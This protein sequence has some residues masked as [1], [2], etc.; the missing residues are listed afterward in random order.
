MIRYCPGRD[1][2]V[3]RESAVGLLVVGEVGKEERAPE[4]D[5][6]QGPESGSAQRI[7]RGSPGE[8]VARGKDS[9]RKNAP[10]TVIKIRREVPRI[11]R[12]ERAGHQRGQPTS[13]P[14]IDGQAA[15][16][17]EELHSPA[18]S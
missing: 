6:R 12:I 7:E 15:R 2:S 9:R 16:Q 13:S 17:R 1:G 4:H 18:P 10:A 14:A 8:A 11:E 3:H 5:R